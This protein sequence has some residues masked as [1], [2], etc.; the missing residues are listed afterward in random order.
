MNGMSGMSCDVLRVGEDFELCRVVLVTSG[1]EVSQEGV[2]SFSLDLLFSDLT[3]LCFFLS[4]F[5]C[6][7]FEDFP[8]V[9]QRHTGAWSGGW[10]L[11]RLYMYTHL[12]V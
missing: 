8:T 4:I 7:F 9:I 1:G 3:G 2:W 6:F 5:L 10:R 12:Y 11:Y